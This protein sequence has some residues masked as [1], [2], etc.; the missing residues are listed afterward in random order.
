MQNV[1]V[2]NND[3]LNSTNIY[4]TVGTS[5]VQILSSV[6]LSYAGT[7]R[8]ALLQIHNP[9]NANF[10][11]CTFDGVAPVVF[12]AGYTIAPLATFVL[13][14]LIPQGGPLTLIGSNASS[15]YTITYM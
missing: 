11:A 2:N 7:P 10:L 14:T 9:S 5:A 4:G 6:T 12:G 3:T 13:D 15:V 8:R 1:I